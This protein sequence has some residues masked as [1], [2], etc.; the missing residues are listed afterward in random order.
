MPRLSR[1]SFLAASAALAARPAAGAVSASGE[2]DVV[3]VGAGAAGIAAARRIAA[4]KRKLR[5]DRSGRSRRR[6]LHHRYD[7]LSACPTTAAPTGSDLPD[8]N[9]VAKAGAAPRGSISIRRRQA[10][11]AHRPTLR[12]EG[13]LEDFLAARCAPIARSSSG[14]RKADVA[15]GQALPQRPRRLAAGGR[16]RA[17]PVRLRQGACGSLRRGF[18]EIGRTRR[19]C[20]LPAGFRHAARQLA[21]GLPVELS[22]PVT[23][24]D[25]RPPSVEVETPKGTS[26]ARAAIVTASTNVIAAGNIKFTP[27]LPARQLDA[28]A[29][30]ALGSYDRIALELADNPLGLESDELVFEKSS[31]TSTAATPRQR[32]RHAALLRRRRAATSARSCR[33][34]EA[35]MVD[36]AADWLADLLRRGHEKGDQA[37]GMRRL[38][39]GAVG[40]RRLFRRAPGGHSRRAASSWSRCTTR[41]VSPARPRT[42]RCGARSAVPGN[43]ASAPPMRCCTGSAVRR[44]RFRSKPRRQLPK[45]KREPKRPAPAQRQ[46]FEAQP[47]IMRDGY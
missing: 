31:G 15:C 2:V 20:L 13:E 42:R 3:I 6:P 22:T 30:L 47:R 35:A 45:S 7:A 1:R 28:M 12:A 40:A 34:G 9:P 21:E 26:V 39:Q 19:R 33:Q 4:A 44:S 24:I 5:G 32:F 25:L 43:P 36:F 16:V 10:K 11:G 14:A 18:R 38:D 37:H 27:A 29:K 23:A 46:R 41:S 17:R 8:V